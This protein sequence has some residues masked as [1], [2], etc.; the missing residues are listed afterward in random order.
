MLLITGF[1]VAIS[2]KNIYAGSLDDMI[3][4]ETKEGKGDKQAA[5]AKGLKP[6]SMP[7]N[8]EIQA[9]VFDLGAPDKN[10]QRSWTIMV[11]LDADNNLESFGIAD[12]NEMEAGLTGNVD[13][14]VLI[15]RAKGYD[16]SNGNWT[17]AQILRIRSDKDSN[18]ISSQVL[19]KPGELNMGDPNVLNS[20][21]TSA[22]K[23]F[24][25]KHYG[26]IMW[27]HGGGWAS[28]A[29]DL[30][31][32]GN[33]AGQDYLTLPEL[34]SAIKGA[35]GKSGLKRLDLIGFDM[36]LMAQIETAVELDGLAEVMIASEAVEPGNGWP[37]NDF[38]PEFDKGTRGTRRIA[39]SIVEKYADFYKKKNTEAY[40]LSALDLT[41]TSK[42]LNALD[43]VSDK[44]ASGLDANWPTVSSA[45]FF[46]ESYAE[47]TEVQR[48]K[49]ALASL[50]I[51]DSLKRMQLNIPNFPASQELEAFVQS[52][53][54]FIIA[55]NTSRAHR[56]SNGIAVYAPVTNKI[57]NEEYRKTKFAGASR[58][59]AMMDKLHA[60]QTKDQTVPV[61]RDLRL[62][63]WKNLKKDGSPTPVDKAYPLSTQGISYTVEGRNILWLSGMYG[64]RTKDGKNFI[65]HTKSTVTDANWT[66]KTKDM[67]A[68]K[69]DLLVPEYEDGINQRI[70]MFS[71]Y[72]YAVSNGKDAYYAT[73][74]IPLEANGA[75][76]IP[77]QYND[78]KIG[79]LGGTVYF[80]PKLWY[81]TTVVLE[82]PQED[83]SMLFRQVEPQSDAEVTML[84][85]AITDKGETTYLK[86]GTMKW[87]EGLELVLSLYNPGQYEVNLCAESIGGRS[88]PEIYKF[89]VEQQAGTKEVIEAGAKFTAQDLLGSW[90]YINPD[91]LNNKQIETLGVEVTFSENPDQNQKGF[92]IAEAV[93]ST[94]NIRDRS[95][96]LVDTR[97]FPHVRQFDI[98]EDGSE[99][100]P[101]S[102]DFSVYSI[103][104]FKGQRTMMLLQN[105]ANLGIYAAVKKDS[106]QG[107]QTQGMAAGAQSQTQVQGQGFTQSTQAATGLD[108]SWSSSDGSTVIFQGKQYQISENGQVIDAGTLTIQG[109]IL[110]TQSSVT[111]MPG[112][113]IF[114]IK[115]NILYLQDA[116]GEVYQF[117]RS[118]QQSGSAFGQQGQQSNQGNQA[119]TGTGGSTSSEI[120]RVLAGT[121][122]DIRSSGNTVITINSNGTF[123][124]YS[125]Y[126]T[127]GSSSDQFGDTTGSWGTGNQKGMQGRWTA[128][129]TPQKG[130][131][132]YQSQSGEQG[133]LSYQVNIE[134]GQVYW[135]ECYFDGALYSRQ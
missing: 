5:Q 34:S 95:M 114:Q 59:S 51:L 128:Q 80:A 119:Q 42:V 78:P 66:K 103:G 10:P 107:Y 133:T 21:L 134:N 67:A 129:G 98:P 6:V 26:L 132:L 3:S 93:N 83:G 46:S 24:P 70:I 52:L 48:T 39:A 92:L 4:L 73:I 102:G 49:H 62:V 96:V 43:K 64:E 12:I 109:N 16:D 105:I 118:G 91:K 131:I 99:M 20:F 63:D 32:P 115:S 130:T 97:G 106:G 31:L 68:D 53:D 57:F 112:Q 90:D 113:Y 36:C 76:S 69:I 8:H 11:Y 100:D 120:V 30:L 101:L 72:R 82:L 29:H 60:I 22:I 44:L 37:Y 38:L 135:N 84:F 9:A 75:M 55:S 13:I 123:S 18:K 111:N 88:I 127:W 45:L 126:A 86:G 117:N 50:D 94:K 33:A 116:Y 108:G 87:G 81:S 74:N 27:D 25:A 89:K 65:V 71:G 19:A 121:W 28:H 1:V 85:E 23:T 122:K 77:I 41:N 40:T 124:Y 104:V 2:I 110:K 35:F 15:D 47:R 79:L 54:T 14:I 7:E 58:W 56:L 125:D 17:D 61:V